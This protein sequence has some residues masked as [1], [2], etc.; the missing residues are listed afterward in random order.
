MKKNILLVAGGLAALSVTLIAL[1]S[2]SA[3]V[4]EQE[5]AALQQKVQKLQEVSVFRSCLRSSWDSSK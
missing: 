1:P 3:A 2:P 5:L 4:Q